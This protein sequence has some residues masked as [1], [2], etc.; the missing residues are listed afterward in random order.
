VGSNLIINLLL[1]GSLNQIWT[2]INTL[3][4]CVSMS[5][6]KLAWP[7]NTTSLFAALMLLTSFGFVPVA[8]LID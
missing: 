6:Y 2:L 3:Q 1:G 8:A 5:L 7:A 4:I